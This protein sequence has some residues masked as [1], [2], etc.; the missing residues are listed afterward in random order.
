MG[1]ESLALSLH[2]LTW[3]GWAAGKESRWRLGLSHFQGNPLPWLPHG[4]CTPL[5]PGTS[6]WVCLGFSGCEVL[7]VGAG[8]CKLS[9]SLEWAEAIDTCSRHAH[10]VPNPQRSCCRRARGLW[11]PGKVAVGL[12]VG[13][14]LSDCSQVGVLSGPHFPQIRSRRVS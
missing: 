1:V 7:G 5:C 4:P 2:S 6:S 3:P 8:G 10:A 13:P 9:G 12:R 14:S 11:M